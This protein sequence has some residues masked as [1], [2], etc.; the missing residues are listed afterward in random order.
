[1][2]GRTG[3]RR[4]AARRSR[5]SG[6]AVRPSRGRRPGSRRSPA[7]RSRSP[8]RSRSAQESP[9]AGRARPDDGGDVRPRVGVRGARRSS[10]PIR[11]VELPARVRDEQVHPAIPTEVGR[12]DAH[13]GVRV[14]YLQLLRDFLEAEVE[15]VRVAAHRD[16]A[17]ELVRIG[18]VRDVQV[19]TSV[20]VD[21]G[22]HRAEPVSDE[23]PLDAGSLGDLPEPRA[24]LVVRADIEVQQVA[25]RQVVRREAGRRLDPDVRV[26]IRRH[27]DVGS[28]VAV[29]VS[30]CSCGV[31]AG[32]GDAGLRGPFRERAVAVVPQQRVV[33][34]GG[35]VVAG[36][37]HVDVRMPVEVQVGGD[38]AVA[39]EGE[40][41]A[42][43]VSSRPRSARRRFG[44]A[45]S[46]GARRVPRRR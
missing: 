14:V 9:H 39:A 23:L 40:I 24:T 38:A 41:G 35:H 17:I 10:A 1:M 2:T 29:D 36:A 44:R 25:E 33:S 28:A 11:G 15:A 20:A 13:A 26:G 21:V 5:G 19:E 27:E 45:H 16:V 42:G 7:P 6:S 30:D 34:V 3:F 43:C 8:S 22:E 46:V 37:R 12:C 18:V 32:R 4:C 31:P